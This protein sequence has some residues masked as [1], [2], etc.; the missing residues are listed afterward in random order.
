MRELVGPLA[1]FASLRHRLAH[2]RGRS[3]DQAALAR[4]LRALKAEIESGL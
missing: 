2:V 3:A 1:R 4:E